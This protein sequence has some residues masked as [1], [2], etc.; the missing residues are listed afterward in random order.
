M[1]LPHQKL[2]LPEAQVARN[3]G[4]EINQISCKNYGAQNIS[5]TISVRLSAPDPKTRPSH[6][7]P[8]SEPR[9][10]HPDLLFL[11]FW[12]FLAFF[13]F[14]EFLAFLRGF[15]PFSQGF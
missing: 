3:Y 7:R 12:D 10:N 4:T 11:A 2:T 1:T 14:K 5:K 8:T 13:L 9:P 15:F 6:L